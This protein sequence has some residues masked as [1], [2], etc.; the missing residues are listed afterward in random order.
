M[1]QNNT[2]PLAT[3]TVGDSDVPLVF[4]HGL[5]GRGKNFASNA[6][7]L[8]NV[9][10]CTLVDL[11]NHGESPWTE[12]F[13]Y[14]DM[15]HSVAETIAPIA[16]E[17]GPVNLLGHSMGG[18]VAM[19]VALHHPELIR[20]LVVEDIS[21]VVAKNMSEFT[22]L[23]GS[24]KKLDL[25]AI[26][27]RS[28]ADAELARYVDEPTV[29]AF[30]LQN[31]RRGADGFEWQPNLDLLQASLADIGGFPVEETQEPFPGQTLWMGGALSNYVTDAAE[32]AMRRL[33]PSTTRVTIKNA[34]H[35]IHSEQ[36]A[37]FETALRTFL[38]PE[39]S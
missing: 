16:E 18:K 32:P 37:A 15:A 29:R 8:S 38:N 22:H 11:P 9:F 33:F 35:W 3:A 19:L 14:L 20:R 4:L 10:R 27:S 26:D 23:L 36:P 12:T 6:K 25:A 2:P 34:T 5:M 24:L 39:R 7:R 30:L 21:P 17:F 28:Q 31:L 13:S 1:A